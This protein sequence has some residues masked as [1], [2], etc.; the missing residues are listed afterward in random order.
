MDARVNRVA[1]VATGVI[2]ASWAACFL[3]R[4]LDV[5]ATDPAP[6][7]GQRLQDAV[8]RHWPALER[9]GLAPGASRARLQFHAHVQDAV[10]EADFVQESGPE[11]L[12]AKQELLR[13]IDA[14]APP[15]AI[16]A[17]SSSGLLVTAMQA[18]C[19]HPERV[20]LGHP[21]NPPHIIPLVE[22]G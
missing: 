6:G 19:Q 4:G 18:G 17:T 5:H 14:A 10:A 20:V 16:V 1:V 13:S 7:A 15:G 12:E 9:Q 22:V 3:A 8:A 21:F 11:R 2:G